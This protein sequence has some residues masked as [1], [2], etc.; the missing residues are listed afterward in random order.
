MLLFFTFGILAVSLAYDPPPTGPSASVEPH[1]FLNT[2]PARLD[3]RPLVFA[4]EYEVGN[5]PSAAHPE[6]EERR[7]SFPRRVERS[8]PSIPSQ[9]K[10]PKV[11][12]QILESVLLI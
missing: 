8:E 3:A 12:F 1:R 10:A 4:L 9:V 6:L 11:S 5:V 2:D 7:S